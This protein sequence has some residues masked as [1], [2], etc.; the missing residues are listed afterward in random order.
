MKLPWVSRERFDEE[1]E[2]NQKLEAE[3]NRLRE[4]LIPQLRTPPAA[5]AE[6]IIGMDTDLSKIQP[7]AGKVTLSMV[8]SAANREAYKRSQTAGAKSVA[9]ELTE[10]AQKTRRVSHGQ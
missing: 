4:L 8:T 3:L 1:R 9:E 7:I 6:S 2:R 5:S 10:N